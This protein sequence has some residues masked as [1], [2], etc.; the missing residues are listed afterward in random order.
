MEVRGTNCRSQL[1][2]NREAVVVWL[3]PL[4]A[5]LQVKR[6]SIHMHVAVYEKIVYSR[7]SLEL[8]LLDTTQ[9]SM[10]VFENLFYGYFINE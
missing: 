6:A 3:C 2:N 7:H 8:S 10:N 4:A 5:K 1:F 9:V